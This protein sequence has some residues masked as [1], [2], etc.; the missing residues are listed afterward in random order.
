MTQTQLQKLISFLTE[1]LVKYKR[2]LKELDIPSEILY[3]KAKES[4]GRDM[5]PLHNIF[6]CAEAVNNIAFLSLRRPIGGDVSTYRMIK[7]LKNTPSR[8]KPVS[9]REAK[10]GDII[11]SPTGYGSGELKN[12]HVGIISD[13]WKIMSNNSYNGLWEE[14]YTWDS[15]VDRYRKKGGFPVYL[16]QIIIN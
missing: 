1:L 3:K 11:I 15:W 12:G 7:A 16:F 10:R 9:Y 13:D 6:G 2:M 14:N 8:F 5:A 4:I